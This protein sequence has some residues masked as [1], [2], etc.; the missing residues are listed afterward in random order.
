MPRK[1]SDPLTPLELEIMKVLW[2]T[3][4]AAAQT[5]QERPPGA[6]S[7]PTTRCRRCSTCCSARAG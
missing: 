7:S 6:R 5:V 1:T 3:G 4:P 2:Q